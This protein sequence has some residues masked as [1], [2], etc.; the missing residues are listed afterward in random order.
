MSST[1][2]TLYY[3]RRT[4]YLPKIV[5]GTPELW[6]QTIAI[7]GKDHYD[8]L[9]TWSPCG[10]LVAA[11]TA[12]AVEIRNQLTLEL[13]TILQPTETIPRLTGPLAYSP[14][15][16]SIACASDTAIVIWDIQT[17]GVAKEIECS[18]HNISL[19]WSSDGQTICTIDSEDRVTF[20]VHTYN[21][22]SG[23]ASSPGKFES[24]DNP[25]LWTDEESFWVMATVR[26]RY[27][28]NTID[29]LKVGSTLSKTRSSI[30]PPSEHFE[31]RI[32]SFSPTT[33]R[34]SIS[35]GPILRIFDIRDSQCLS[36]KMGHFLSHCFS[37]DGSYF[38]ASREG[39]VY[40]WKYAFKWYTLLMDFRCQGLSNSLRFSPT[41][42]SILGYSGDILQMW[43]L[44]ELP[45]AFKTRRLYVGLSHSGT[46]VAVAHEEEKAVTI[47]DSLL[48]QTPPQIID[49]DVAILGLVL[50]GNVLL[51]AGSNKLT[52]WLLTGEGLVDGI[53][54]GRRVGYSDSIW[55]VPLSLPRGDSW[56]FSV[57]G[58]VGVIKQ[59]GD[60][61]HVYRTDTGKVLHPIQALQHFSSRWYDP[62]ETLC[63]QDY[64][65]YHNLPQRNA[66]PKDSWE[67]SRA[68]LRKGWVKDAEGKHRLWVPV[69]WRADWD[70][71]DWR[72]D[73][74]TQFSHLGGRSVIIKF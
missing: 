33:H 58:Q 55:T 1:I 21:V 32:K 60:A 62:T 26:G 51:V 13:I 36:E 41:P 25:H 22:S 15:G 70:P 23:T 73:V 71:A 45:I 74:T 40:I 12:K 47:I 31:S 20:I 6:T 28:H 43:R 65:C 54:G 57:E 56:M 3:R 11:Q 9:C 24:G 16:R 30:F 39:G 5:V 69:E 2:R 27:N 67:I 14:D 53:I 48:A 64:L 8:G 59:D 44:H 35:N 49:T 52:A 17:G 68:T 63:G 19:L 61:L 34:V 72:H 66:P 7:S 38:A 42:S 46:R 37:S 4:T 18:P 50:T 10:R 29:I